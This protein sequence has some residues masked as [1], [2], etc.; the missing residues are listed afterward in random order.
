ME[1][2]FSS[3][4]KKEKPVGTILTIEKSKSKT[5]KR[6]KI[7]AT[8]NEFMKKLAGSD[9]ASALHLKDKLAVKGKKR[10]INK[11]RVIRVIRDVLEIINE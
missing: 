7:P 1:F 4:G 6:K 10:A 3:L 11:E 9:S 5:V 8:F 2:D